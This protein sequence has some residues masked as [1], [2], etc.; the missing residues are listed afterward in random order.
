MKALK[1]NNT[2][3]AGSTFRGR[4]LKFNIDIT[5]S[6]FYLNVKDAFGVLI[7]RID[8]SF[9]D[10][11]N[12]SFELT[13]IEHLKQDQYT[14]EYWAEFD[15]LGTEMIALERFVVVNHPDENLEDKTLNFILNTDDVYIEFEINVN[16]INIVG[17]SNNDTLEDVLLRGN[18]L[19]TPIVIDLESE[20]YNGFISDN[21]GFSSYNGIN[22]NARPSQFLRYLNYENYSVLDRDVFV[23]GSN[24]PQFK[25]FEAFDYYGDRA[26]DNTYIQKKYVDTQKVKYIT[27]DVTLDHTYNNA[28]C[29]VSA[30]CVISVPN[31]LPLG[32]SCEFDVIGMHTPEIQSSVNFPVT[33]S[34]PLGKV[35]DVNS[36][37]RLTRMTGNEFRLTGK[38]SFV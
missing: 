35:M 24:S 27:S 28:L 34:A 20:M 23:I 21:G 19:R 32:F 26:T 17:G 30:D 6:N 8:Y 3:V 37:C 16:V 1:F 14:I 38:L 7:E 10:S 25:G 2:E 12:V 9:K 36:Q 22:I 5:N 11:E 33:F 4:N 13:N 18:V 29:F 31:N 15:T